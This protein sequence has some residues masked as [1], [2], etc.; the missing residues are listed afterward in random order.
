MPDMDAPVS[1]SLALGPLQP[2]LDDPAVVEI[3]VNGPGKVFVERAGQGGMQFYDMPELTATEI[4]WI[5]E[6]IAGYSNQFVNEENPLL[7]AA[8]PTG[9]RVQIVRA[10][11]AADGGAITI[12]KQ[13]VKNLSLADYFKGGSFA[14]VGVAG[15]GVIDPIDRH[16]NALLNDGSEQAVFEFFRFAIRS[17]VTICASGGTGGGKTTFLNAIIKDIP[18]DERII[19][20]EDTRELDIANPNAVAL[21]TSRNDQGVAKVDA[22]RLLE[23]C[24]RMRPDRLLI[25]ELRG[26]ECFAFLRAVNTGHPGSLTSIHANSPD[27][28]YE[29]M[30]LL[31]TQGGVQLPHDYLLRYLHMVIPVIVQ[32]GKFE[33]GR[34]G[35]VQEIFFT[36]RTK[37]Q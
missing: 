6:R 12:R 28:A 17:K 2:F 30:A 9:E 5:S 19:T 23:A 33:D 32:V 31:I 24:L 8:L 36:R 27:A 16:L 11:A 25:G 7:S 14:G 10:P 1:L 18:A 20:I 37:K 26:Q 4:A 29:Q 13:V 22:V 21:L 34:P 15:S 3:C 35:K